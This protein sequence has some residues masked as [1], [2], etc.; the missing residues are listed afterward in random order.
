MK[1]ETKFELG[2]EIF[3][4]FYR[5]YRWRIWFFRI[6]KIVVTDQGL[7]YNEIF[8]KDCFATKEEAQKECDKRNATS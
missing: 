4:L 6:A 3:G 1:I 8:A 2:Q 7:Q 5:G